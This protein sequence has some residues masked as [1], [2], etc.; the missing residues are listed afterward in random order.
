MQKVK[1]VLDGLGRAG[2]GLVWLL[3]AAAGLV[4]L[5]LLSPVLL[6]ARLFRRA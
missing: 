4:V 5:I 2:A 3:A 1:T 6:V